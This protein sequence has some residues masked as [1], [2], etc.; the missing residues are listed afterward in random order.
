MLL[1]WGREDNTKS[2]KRFDASLPTGHI[3]MENQPCDF[4]LAFD[5]GWL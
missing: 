2:K 1:A 3:G 5:V 4:V